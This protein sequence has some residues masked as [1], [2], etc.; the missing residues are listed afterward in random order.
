[1]P[2]PVTGSLPTLSADDRWAVPFMLPVLAG[3][4][5]VLCMAIMGLPE[6]ALAHAGAFRLL[7]AAAYVIWSVPLTALQRWLWRRVSPWWMAA[8]LLLATY[9]FSVLNNV[10]A[11][12]LALHWGLIPA[13]SW[14]RNLRGL[15]GCWLALIAFCAIHAVVAYYGELREARSRLREAEGLARDAQLRALRYQLHPHFLY[16]TLNA[17]SSLVVERRPDEAVRML[18][19]LGDLLRATLDS[20]DTHEV[21]LAEEWATT[22]LYLSIEKV[23]LGD[24]LQFDLRAGP[25]VLGALVPCLLLQP[26]VEN[27]IRHGLALRRKPGRL[28]LDI[29]RKGDRL[30]LQLRNDGVPHTHIQDERPSAVGLRNVRDRLQKLYGVEQS[31]DFQLDDSGACTIDITLPFRRRTIEHVAA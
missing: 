3:M 30:H 10:V 24:R 31:F 25:E 5:I 7:F 6:L 18:A 2:K 23:R 1:M 11:Q 9:V 22:E 27:A 16:N 21:A 8:V 19:S 26:L 12:L 29:G 13:F 14:S 20:S 28:E 4:P 17:V 15:D